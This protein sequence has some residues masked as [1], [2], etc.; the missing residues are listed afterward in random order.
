VQLAA[1]LTKGGASASRRTNSSTWVVGDGAACADWT[2]MP[3]TAESTANEMATMLASRFTE[4]TWI[5]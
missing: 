3:A 4:K 5:E 2:K 1:R